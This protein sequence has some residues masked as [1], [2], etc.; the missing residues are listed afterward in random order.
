MEANILTTPFFSLYEPYAVSCALP[1][2]WRMQ[3]VLLTGVNGF[4]GHY[5]AE[6]LIK[7]GYGVVGTGKGT[8]RLSLTEENF[9]YQS[10]DI[11]SD[12]EVQHVFNKY[13]PDTVIHSAAMTK[14]DECVLNNEAAYLINVTG[15]S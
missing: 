15:T 4:T 10:L 7:K 14:P 13:Q 2:F 9:I 12:D 1:Y 5:L 11:T 3:T 8:C 6:Q